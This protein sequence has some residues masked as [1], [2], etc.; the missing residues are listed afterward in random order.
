MKDRLLLA[1]LAIAA[2]W[3]D[4]AVF[5]EIGLFTAHVTGNIVLA[6]VA[7]GHPDG[8]LM[9]KALAVPVFVLVAWLAALL[10]R[11]R[12]LFLIEAALLM[13]CA[14]LGTAAAAQPHGLLVILFGMAGVAAMAVQNAAN[15]LLP[16]L[17]STAVMTSNTVQAMIDLAT[18][19][20]PPSLD[21]RDQARKR[22]GKTLPAMFFFA[23]GCAGGGASLLFGGPKTIVLPALALIAI[24]FFTPSSRA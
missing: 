24:A 8:N 1:S 14:E 13:L 11:P 16:G 21:V 10:D 19:H 2:G 17:P 7:F 12:L 23:A 15:R 3:V 18:L 6:I 20:R 5:C 4:A 22:L 9:M